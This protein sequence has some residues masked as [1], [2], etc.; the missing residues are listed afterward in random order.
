MKVTICI[1]S[2]CFFHKH[3]FHIIHIFCRNM[4]FPEVLAEVSGAA[5]KA[6]ES[7]N[8]DEYLHFFQDMTSFFENY[9]INGLVS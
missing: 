6:Y 4:P 7:H 5:E 8:E 1:G 9:T 2:A 3:R